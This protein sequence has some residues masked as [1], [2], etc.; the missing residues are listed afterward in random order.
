[1]STLT[2]TMLA[3]MAV[4]QG[5]VSKLGQRMETLESTVAQRDETLEALIERKVAAHFEEKRTFNADIIGEVD[6]NAWQDWAADT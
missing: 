6:E 5:T 3:E 4:L 2:S 1:M